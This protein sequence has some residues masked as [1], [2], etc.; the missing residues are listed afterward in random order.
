MSDMFWAI[1]NKSLFTRPLSVQN[2]FDKVS[3]TLC[4]ASF[5]KIG[6]EMRLLVSKLLSEC[7]YVC[8]HVSV[9]QLH[10][11]AQETFIESFHKIL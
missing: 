10:R 3:L 9:E 4:L 7:L 5:A 6:A 8:P 1:R 2:R 11:F